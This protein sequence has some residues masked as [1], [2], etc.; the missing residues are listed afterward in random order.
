[1]PA[2]VRNS[3]DVAC[4]SPLTPPRLTW[5]TGWA[6]FQLHRSVASP[7]TAGYA[8]AWSDSLWDSSG[9]RVNGASLVGTRPRVRSWTAG[10][11]LPGPISSNTEAR[12]RSVRSSRT[13]DGAAER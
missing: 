13:A 6:P 3:T 5:V 1:T 7:F 12:S 10:L 4:T 11:G 2:G 8:P 9:D